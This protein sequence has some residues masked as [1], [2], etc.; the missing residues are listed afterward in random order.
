VRAVLKIRPGARFLAAL[1]LALALLPAAGTASAREEI[2]SY[3]A[4][5]EVQPDG[6][7]DVTET[8]RVRAE[9]RQIRRGIYRDFPTRY[10]RPDGLNR[11]AGFEIV[12][13][14]KNGD[15]EPYHTEFQSV[16]V[17]VYIGDADTLIPSGI[18]TYTIRYLTTR[19]L[20]FFEDHDELYWNVTGNF[21]SFPILQAEARV[22]LP[23]GARI[24]ELNAFTGSLGQQGD[25][26]RIVS[27]ADDRFVI[28]TERP[29]EAGQGLTILAT[30]QKGLVPT[31]TDAQEMAYLLW[32][33]LG[34]A[35]L[36]I[37]FA[38]ILFY[39]LATWNRL[40]RDPDKGTIIPL[41]EPPEGVSPAAASYLHHWGFRR[42]SGRKPLA[43]MAAII[44]LAVKGRVQLEQQGKTML[45]SLTD[46]QDSPVSPGEAAILQR[47]G[48]GGKLSFKKSSA[49]RVQAMRSAFRKAVTKDY[50]RRYIRNNIGWFVLG[51]VLTILAIVAF[52]LLQLP[53]EDQ[54]G[55]M[56]MT[57]VSGTIGSAMLL[58]GIG[59]LGELLPGS[60]SKLLGTLYLVI[61][62]GAC[63]TSIFL[64]ASFLSGFPLA[65]ALAMP[66]LG[67]MNVAF[68][69]LLRAPTVAGRDL[70]DRIEGFRLYLS[71]AEAERM[72]MAGA[73][74]VTTE[75]FERYLPYAIGL[76]VEKPWSDAFASH[77]ARTMP[78]RSR[79]TSY[80]PGWYSGD[81]FS[82]A[83]MAAATGAMVAAMSSSIASATPSSSGSGGGGSSGGG[84][85]GG[86]GG[87]W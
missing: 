50:D 3:V 16:G 70:L 35:V 40:G 51:L 21:W 17:R 68:L 75:I 2:L 59:I 63:T 71:V 9:R 18:Y 82:S 31:P 20:R 80:H 15:P 29:L 56:I 73:P 58:L 43:F 34:F 85:G 53:P 78:T 39:Y 67:A 62:I 48:S 65:A 81:S 32:D 52:F 49:T 28:R 87:G 54:T 23:E 36:A 74:D 41:F 13:I 69:H 19:Q 37:A 55:P 86:G 11:K 24:G 8:I 42:A 5:I 84:G 72:N 27:R 22:R 46:N 6:T 26:F 10:T 64:A 4:D 76:N 7:L 60:G 57:L 79:D 77:I 1:L 44:S 30:F 25:N 14:L 66:L 38:S 12:S 45:M 61:G 83:N 47:L 33:N